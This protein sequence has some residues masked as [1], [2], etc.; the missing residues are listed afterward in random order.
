[1]QKERQTFLSLIHA[2]VGWGTV[3]LTS[4]VNLWQFSHFFCN[5]LLL[6]SYHL[7]PLDY[8][9]T[10]DWRHSYISTPCFTKEHYKPFDGN[11]FNG[12]NNVAWA[13]LWTVG[14]SPPSNRTLVS[15][16]NK[17]GWHCCNVLDRSHEIRV[18]TKVHL[19]QSNFSHTRIKSSTH[20]ST[21]TS[22][23]RFSL[24]LQNVCI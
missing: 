16:V 5:K 8:T 23:Y 13:T 20:G 14:F 1:M 9:S 18:A 2:C 21:A 19:W 22:I 6:S 10:A 11:I 4:H 24:A 12:R 17:S 3:F 15:E 7:I